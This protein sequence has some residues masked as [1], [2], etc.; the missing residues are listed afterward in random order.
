MQKMMRQ[1]WRRALVTAVIAAG[2]TG[3]GPGTQDRMEE[4]DP[5]VKRALARKAAGDTDGAIELFERAIERKPSLARPHLDLGLL[6]DQVKTNYVR[7]IYHYER[8]L[9]LRPDSEKKALINELIYR[10][11][12]N[13]AVSLP[14]RPSSAVQ[15]IA[16]LKEE[17][18]S[19][20]ARL[21]D[22]QSA[23]VAPA[24]PAN[25][26]G[27]GGAAPPVK[28]KPPAKG[29]APAEAVPPNPEPA[30][31]PVQTY[32]VQ[33]GDTLSSIAIRMYRD[34]SKWKLIYDA[35]RGILPSPQSVRPGQ[36]LMI[37]KPKK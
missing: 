25:A 2:L 33:A 17:I 10:T 11:R 8:Y 14:D 37:P 21:A 1:A 31:P 29:A 27:A 22:A 20:K 16:M 19:L 4:R 7:A 6:Y 12:L 34:Q 24:A 3:C 15:E 13:Y 28:G 26:G 5:L 30:Q 18:K 23:P 36:T 32:V 35:N 9:E